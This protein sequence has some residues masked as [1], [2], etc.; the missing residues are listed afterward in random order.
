MNNQEFW[1]VGKNHS[2]YLPQVISNPHVKY[3]DSTHDVEKYVKNCSET[4]GVLL[5]RTTIEGWMCG[6]PGWIYEINNNGQK[7]NKKLHNPP[8]DIE[9]FYLSN[10]VK[11]IT[12]EYEKIL[13]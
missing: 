4:A 9:K 3:F 12:I 11:Q 8:T 7:L 10:V 13:N 2:N 1:L 6:K 5:G